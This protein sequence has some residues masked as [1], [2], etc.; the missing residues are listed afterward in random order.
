VYF[1]LSDCT[2][3][4]ESVRI[5]IKQAGK[6]AKG[7]VLIS[8]AFL[9]KTDNVI[10]AAKAGI[11]AIIQ[12]GGSIADKDVIRAADQNKIAMVM[13]DLRHFKH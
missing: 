4:V 3:R 5:A 2:S 11:A 13:T 10:L 1:F 6:K 12:T 7:A 8:D 9:P